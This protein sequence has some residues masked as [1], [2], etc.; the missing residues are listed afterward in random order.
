VVTDCRAARPHA[1]HSK[2][3]KKQRCKFPHSKNI[4]AQKLPSPTTTIIAKTTEVNTNP[5]PPPTL[6]PSFLAPVPAPA[7]EPEEPEEPEEPHVE[8]TSFKNGY[9]LVSNPLQT[10]LAS[11]TLTFSVVLNID[12]LTTHR[13]RENCVLQLSLQK[14]SMI[15]G[16]LSE[17]WPECPSGRERRRSRTC[18]YSYDP[19]STNKFLREPGGGAD[20]SLIQYDQYKYSMN[21]IFGSRSEEMVR[22]PR[23][24]LLPES[25][26]VQDLRTSSR[27]FCKPWKQVSVHMALSVSLPNLSATE[28]SSSD[29]FSSHSSH[30]MSC[31][32]ALRR[33]RR[34]RWR[35]LIRRGFYPGR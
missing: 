35:G 7:P 28:K 4:T 1:I 5:T 31:A 24:S 23:V 33:I 19:V 32:Y 15:S 30:G 25:L 10:F 3:P 26:S 17:S 6:P 2:L 21:I 27:H 20:K 18:L 13:I 11:A 16:V 14:A 22:R 34:G 29:F 9:L 8:F 12:L